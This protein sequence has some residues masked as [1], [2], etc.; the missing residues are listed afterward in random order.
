[1]VETRVLA[2]QLIPAAADSVL[3]T[4]ARNAKTRIQGFT[5]VNESAVQDQFSLALCKQ[6]A[7]AAPANYVY[8]LLPI[9]GDDTFL[10]ELDV[11]LD[12]T[13]VIRVYSLNGT[14]A[15]TLYGLDV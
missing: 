5:F 15:V 14:T 6:G 2:Q 1:M 8:Y 12:Q 7:P 4:V 10:S 3:Y 13:D 11:V 9:V